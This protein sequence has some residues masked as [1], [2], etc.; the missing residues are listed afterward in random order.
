MQYFDADLHFHGLYAGGVSKNMKIPIIAEQAALKGLRLLATGDILNKEWLKHVKESLVEEDKCLKEE[1]SG[2]NFILAT[3]IE[4]NAR[5]HHLIYFPGYEA[6][7][8]LREKLKKFGKLD[9]F[10]NGRPRLSLNA[11]KIAEY[12]LEVGAIIG[13]AH[14]FTPYFSA[15]AHFNSLEELYKERIEEIKFLEL[16]LSADS[17]MADLIS[18]NHKLVFLSNSDAHSPWPHRLGREFNRF[19]MKKGNFEELKNAILGRKERKLVFNAGLNPKE[20]KYHCTACNKCYKKYSLK[21]AIASGW[22]CSCGGVIKR[23]VRDRILMLKDCEVNSKRQKYWHILPLAEIIQLVLKEKNVQ[24]KKVQQKWFQLVNEFESEIKILLDMP[25]D[26]IA[27]IDEMVAKG[28][29]AFR[30]EY[31]L[32]IPG[33]GGKYGEAILC[34]SKEEVENKKIELN[35]SLECAD[36]KQKTLFEF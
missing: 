23:G 25:I 15:Y 2:V 34:F 29:N 1:I 5:V 10:G 17:M 20:G 33:G 14:A 6:V 18:F 31:V 9:G 32:Y 26:E 35:S 16:G 7:E 22:K 12:V 27:K 24:S 4:C 13:P 8:E 30:N 36:E 19:L 21:E 11:E 28:I 3:E